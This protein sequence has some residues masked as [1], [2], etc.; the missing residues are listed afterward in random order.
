MQI[1]FILS[2]KF[3]GELKWPPINVLIFFFGVMAV[4][5]TLLMEGTEVSL[6]MCYFEW[7]FL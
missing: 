6:T 5:K 4:S 3:S 2:Q 7:K 1:M